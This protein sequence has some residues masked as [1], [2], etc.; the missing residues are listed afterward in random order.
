[1]SS[2]TF[3]V[4][5]TT[6]TFVATI[7]N[8]D[9]GGEP[10]W[11]TMAFRVRVDSSAEWENLLALRTRINKTPTPSGDGT[12]D[13]LNGPGLGT[14]SIAGLGSGTAYLTDV[15]SPQIVPTRRFARAT[16]DVVTWT[17]S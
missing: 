14:L 8:H 11:R 6:A 4:G 17:P 12:R 16:F 7:A 9:D 3:Q 10:P 15:G 1:M 13:E 5:G 2:S